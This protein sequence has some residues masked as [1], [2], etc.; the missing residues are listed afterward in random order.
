MSNYDFG[1][2]TAQNFFNMGN[3]WRMNYHK[4]II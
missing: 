2:E 4:Y 1:Q 3:V